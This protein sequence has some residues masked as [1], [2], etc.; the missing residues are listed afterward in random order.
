MLMLVFQRV[1]R[2]LAVLSTVATLALACGAVMASTDSG[3]STLRALGQDGVR[4]LSG[5]RPIVDAGAA[6]DL[7]SPGVGSF[8]VSIGDTGTVSD[9][10]LVTVPLT[11]TCTGQVFSS[12]QVDQA[13]GQQVAHAFAGLQP[14]C[15]GVSRTYA[16]T[17]T[18]QNVPFKP[19]TAVVSVFATLCSAFTCQSETTTGTIKLRRA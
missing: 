14:A 3:L 15:D 11:I 7:V 2:V 4:T 10:L 6:P 13:A 19:G 1:K 5:L 12:M 9:K 18:A 16:V 8:T 17:A